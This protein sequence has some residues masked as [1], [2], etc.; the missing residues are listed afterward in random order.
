MEKTFETNTRAKFKIWSVELNKSVV[1]PTEVEDIPTFVC[2]A[3]SGRS[4]NEK[5][6]PFNPSTLHIKETGL[7]VHMD[8]NLSLKFIP[9]LYL[10]RIG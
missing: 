10:E 8:K 5:C 6:T 9:V 4:F 3:F 1:W 7:I 2:N